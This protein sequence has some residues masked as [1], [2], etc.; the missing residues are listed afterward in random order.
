MLDIKQ[1]L[2]CPGLKLLSSCQLC[3]QALVWLLHLQFIY[4]WIASFLQWQKISRVIADDA[5][6]TAM[7]N[8]LNTCAAYLIEITTR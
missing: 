6:T 2:A 7:L 1:L 3:Y 5:Q 4:T 8:S